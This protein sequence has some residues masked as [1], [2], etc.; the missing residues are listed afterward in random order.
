MRWNRRRV[1]RRHA[2]PPLL[3][4]L[5]AGLH[6]PTCP[7]PLAGPG[8][9]TVCEHWRIILLTMESK[10]YR[11][12]LNVTSDLPEGLGHIPL[13]PVVDFG[14]AIRA[15]GL[16]GVLDP[17]S[18]RVVD[19]AD[20]AV[21]PHHRTEDFAYADEGRVEFAVTD[22]ARQEYFIEFETAPAR[23]PLEPQTYV[24]LVGVGD[25]LRYNSV[26]PRPVTMYSM[27]FVDLNGDG[28][29]DLCGTWN[30]YH[31]PGSPISGAVCYPR[32]KNRPGLQVGDMER[33]RYREPGS[34]ELLDFT[35][36]YVDADFADLGGD[37]GIDMVVGE[38]NADHVT[39]LVDSGDRSP[40][41][42]PIF[43]R[44]RRVPVPVVDSGGHGYLSFS[45]VDGDGVPDLVSCGYW[46][47]NRNPD[48]RPFEP[49]DPVDLEAGANVTFLDVDG[50]G[51]QEL[52]SYAKTESRWSDWPEEPGAY[53]GGTVTWRRRLP[54]NEVR[55]GP[56]LPVSGIPHSAFRIAAAAGSDDPALLVRYNPA[57]D[58]IG[59]F[60]V[61][62]I[63]TDT[64]QFEEQERFLSPSAVIAL[65][66][67]SWPCRCDWDGDGV[68]D[69]LV[70]GGYGWPHVL[71]NSGTDAR[72]SFDL[73]HLIKSEGKPVRVLRDRILGSR[74]W[75]NMGYP[76]PSF[77][78][79][80][81]DGVP[82]LMLPN[83]TNRI[84][85][86]KN[87]GSRHE[88]QFGPQQ[89]IEVDGYP[90]SA[91]IRAESGKKGEDSTLAN[92]PYPEDALS[93]FWWRTG[94]AF[95]D[96][97][98]D[99][100]MDFITH[101]EDR[102]ATLFVQ[103]ID[104][105]GR[106]RVRKEGHV[107][108]ADG[109]EI[110]DSV[111]GRKK[112]WTESFR[113]VDWDGDGLTDMVYSNA[114]SGHVYLLLNIGT[115]EKPVFAAPREL[116]YYGTSMEFTIHGP[117]VWPADWNDDGKPDILGCVEWSVY[118]FFAHAALQM[119]EHPA[120]SVGALE[121]VP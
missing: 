82:D 100:V 102:K 29:P 80:D 33:I 76:Y 64:L 51:R 4:H 97:N 120:Y 66:D 118:P 28:L 57:S 121:T 65:T 36:T 67:Q 15:A 75:H 8:S 78:D 31:R 9:L 27:R 25:L 113:P 14:A 60:R 95:A 7:D 39:I 5:P 94:A 105:D 3:A 77:V 111:V 84:V 12:R 63:E 41:G 117:N 37:G 88:P 17:N 34:D 74:H 42:L 50:D 69:L 62:G 20:G 109:R 86:Y 59:L 101:D 96:W 98:G 56:P 35:E 23:P 114:G 103:Y 48:G 1:Q 45:D 73:P 93:P 46:I 43:V 90:D 106:H 119:E 87:V 19:A 61:A 49:D 18:I 24:P 68:Q 104:G 92:H 6:L 54:G 52:I 10:R 38:R 30:Y 44:D 89:F 11:L 32:L 107:L 53:P 26:E 115:V 22:P 58:G 83:E 110:D 91:E 16:P 112:H 81:G 72:P 71:K 13:S 47:R 40:T 2:R 108:L 79:W 21:V 55:F 116:K 85:W 70:G 99:G